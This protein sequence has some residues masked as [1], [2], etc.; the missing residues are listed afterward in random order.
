MTQS[1]PFDLSPLT[2]P[3]LFVDT[4][5]AL[6]FMLRYK[7]RRDKGNE[8]LS[9]DI[10][11]AVDKNLPLITRQRLDHWFSGRR[12]LTDDAFK[13]IFAFLRSEQY[14][15][16]VPEID[17]VLNA[18][19]RTLNQGQV[20]AEFE[21]CSRDDSE[22]LFR[23]VEG[24]WAYDDDIFDH[25]TQIFYWIFPSEGQDF[26][27]FHHCT[28]S[29]YS[30]KIAHPKGLK[31]T[32]TALSVGNPDVISKDGYL[33]N[34]RVSDYYSGFIFLNKDENCYVVKAWSR[35]DRELQYR[36]KL[37]FDEKG[38][39]KSIDTS[40][41]RFWNDDPKKRTND[42]CSKMNENGILFQKNPRREKIA[43]PKN[44]FEIALKSRWS[45]IDYESS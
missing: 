8:I 20:M 35:I 42:F 23:R 18:R 28:E 24:V 17:S 4:R 44:I 19:G 29:V 21:G 2:Y 27:I 34:S 30:R 32:G 45:V 14:K 13:T 10:Y 41:F 36:L 3:P 26:S 33:V 43:V 40:C 39:Y 1:D 22:S 6:E 12:N 16:V 9:T 7:K 15:R 37:R 11:N 25:H 31:N 5:L 38:G